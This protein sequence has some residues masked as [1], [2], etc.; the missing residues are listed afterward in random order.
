MNPLACAA[1]PPPRRP[2]ERFRPLPKP[3]IVF[4]T[5]SMRAPEPEVRLLP[6]RYARVRLVLAM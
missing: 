3:V 5:V 4:L 2:R 6:P 1:S